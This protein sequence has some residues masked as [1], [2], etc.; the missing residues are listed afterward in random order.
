MPDEIFGIIYKNPD[1]RSSDDTGWT[2]YIDF[3]GQ[4]IFAAASVVVHSAT[5]AE[6]NLRLHDHRSA[7]P[8]FKSY[9]LTIDPASVDPRFPSLAG[10]VQIYKQRYAALAWM[11]VSPSREKVFRLKFNLATE[12]A[13]N[14][15]LR[16]KSRN[17]LRRP[18]RPLI[19]PPAWSV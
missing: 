17:R 5:E 10:T 9:R 13:E 6:M 19:S 3:G 1:C 12:V 4:R 2:G 18:A 11:D 16:R 8:C 14:S 15:A 7:P